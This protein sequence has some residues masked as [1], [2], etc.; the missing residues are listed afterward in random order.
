[1]RMFIKYSGL[2]LMTLSG[3]CSA[4]LLAI[5]IKSFDVSQV[6]SIFTLVAGFGGIPFFLGFVMYRWGSIKVIKS[7]E[8]K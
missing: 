7:S 8:N 2:M 5:Q 6:L 1:M 4:G 3:L